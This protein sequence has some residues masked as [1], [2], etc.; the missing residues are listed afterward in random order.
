MFAG[1]RFVF[2]DAYH[3]SRACLVSISCRNNAMIR[4]AV[5]GQAVLGQGHDGDEIDEFSHFTVL[6]ARDVKDERKLILTVSPLAFRNLLSR[7]DESILCY[8]VVLVAGV[9]RIVLVVFQGDR[10]V[11]GVYERAVGRSIAVGVDASGW[12]GVFLGCCLFRF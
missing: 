9:V 6:A 3:S 12:P 2:H 1:T 10:T 8:G 4:F 11:Q 5:S 7:N